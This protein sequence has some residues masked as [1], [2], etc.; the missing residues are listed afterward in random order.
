[1]KREPTEILP[2][3]LALA[4]AWTPQ[5]VREPLRIAFELDQRLARIVARTTEPMLGQMRLA[6]WREALAKPLGDRPKGDAVLDAIGNHWAG[7]EA[8]LTAMIDGWEVLMITERLSFS[9]AASFAEL[10]SGFF[11]AL[12]PLEADVVQ[13]R[14]RLAAIRWALA[15]AVTGVSE[16]QERSVMMAAA[17][18][19]VSDRAQLPK[20]M[21]G[22]AVLDALAQRS[23][24]RGGRPFMEGR[25][26]ALSALKAAIFLR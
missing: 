26:A 21:R 9:D 15:D 17:S 6:W 3:E 7:R 2:I 13:A 11:A 20:A 25:G 5:K 12:A 24:N 23:I 22:L 18:Q 10:R 1:M 16:P 19:K 8:A 4:L 14:I